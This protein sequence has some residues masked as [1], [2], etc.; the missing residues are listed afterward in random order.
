MLVSVEMVQLPRTLLYLQKF[1]LFYQL[2]IETSLPYVSSILSWPSSGHT[3]SNMEGEG[4]TN[5]LA[6]TSVTG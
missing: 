4:A 6:N 5:K 2:Y 3:V 1:Q